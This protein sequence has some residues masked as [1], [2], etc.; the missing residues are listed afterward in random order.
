[1][2]WSTTAAGTISQTARGLFEFLH[3]IGQGGGADGF[4]LD[5]LLHR[6]AAT[7]QRPRID[8]RP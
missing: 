4:F 6:F 2:V 8:G 3:Q 1:M 5:Q 7:G